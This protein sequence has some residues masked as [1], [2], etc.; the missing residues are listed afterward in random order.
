[1]MSVIMTEHE[2]V[3]YMYVYFSDTLVGLFYD[4]VVS[5]S[6]IMFEHAFGS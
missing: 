1:M 2:R 5:A 6:L 3:T 4:Y